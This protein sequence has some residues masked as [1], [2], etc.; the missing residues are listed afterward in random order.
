MAD[1]S[2]KV[3]DAQ[4]ALVALLDAAA[5]LDDYD[6]EYGSV[7]P[8]PEYLVFVSEEAQTERATPFSGQVAAQDEGFTLFVYLHVHRTN[9]TAAEVRDLADVGEA[10]VLAAIAADQTISGTVAFCAVSGIERAGGFWDDK[11]KQ[12]F[13]D[14]KVAVKCQTYL[15]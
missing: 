6:V 2:S 12:R 5:G 7:Q 1:L 9:L 13:T 8:I 4:D 14:R 15:A 10:A 3:S 11:G